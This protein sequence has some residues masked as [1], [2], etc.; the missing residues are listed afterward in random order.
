S[1]VRVH[2]NSP[3]PA[4]VGALAYTQGTEIHLGHG[5]ERHLPH[6]GWHV[7]QQMQGRVRPTVQYRKTAINDEAGLER[8]A[9]VM[10]G[11]ALQFQGGAPVRTQHVSLSSHQPIQRVV[12]PIIMPGIGLAG[13]TLAKFNELL[14]AMNL[15]ALGPA[16]GIVVG[17]RVDD[18]HEP[19]PA[20]TRMLGVGGIDIEVNLRKWYLD[21]ASVGEIV[22]LIAHELGVH[23]L[24]DLMMSRR[25]IRRE[26]RRNVAGTG[27]QVNVNGHQVGVA[28]WA[29]PAANNRDAQ[30][31]QRDHVNVV[32]DQGG[33]AGNASARTQAYVS[34][35]LNLGDNINAGPGTAAQRN[36]KLRDLIRTFLFDYARILVTDDG[37][38]WATFTNADLISHVMQWYQGVVVMRHVGAHPWL[39][40]PA[41]HVNSS[42]WGIRGWLLGKLAAYIANRGATLVRRGFGA[43]GG[44]IAGA[45]NR[46]FG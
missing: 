11:K 39:M 7:V 6:E 35:M 1:P 26:R 34:T 14:A 9:D 22:G 27:F 32:R 43:V 15:L 21:I 31:R 41:V 5:Q 2:Y 8:E 42:G 25:A 13:N 38:P 40:S 23:N 10:G 3:K 19:N 33:V 29:A 12:M 16:A 37:G 45:W 46:V 4:Q 18:S 20:D 36:Q 17:V 28:G 44:A 30:G 24:A